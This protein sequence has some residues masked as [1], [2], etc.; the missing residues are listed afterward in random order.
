METRA[1]YALLGGVTVA[2]GV[3]IML[4]AMWLARASFNREFATYDVVFDGAARGIGAGTE[5]RFNGIR[6][7]EV[8]DLFMDPKNE[9][10]VVARIRIGASWPVRADSEAQ[11]EAIGLTGL[12]LIQI[13]S[14]TG[15]SPR[16]VQRMGDSAPRIKAKGAA[17]DELLAS[18]STIA[19]NAT[20]ALAGARGMLTEENARRVERILVN[21]EKI[22]RDLAAERGAV[23]NVAAAADE[24]RI[25]ARQI[26]STAREV[27]QLSLETRGRV[28]TLET[29]ATTAFN[30]I[31]QAA[32]GVDGA[33]NA[34][35]SGALPDLS[36]AANDM[37]RLAVT[38]DRVAGNVERSRTLSAVGE[39]KRTVRV[40]P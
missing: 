2:A 21:L 38:L 35:A 5:V 28:A 26:S 37:R 17:I 13:S 23:S 4:F 15:T 10:G 39:Q 19:R 9:S 14:G 6:V 25:A 30:N 18:S 29:S 3:L 11:L 8:R 33:A 16:L 36:G 24:W 22:S 31:N 27:E 1:N 12:N 40:D 32:I 34:A 20:E 7:G